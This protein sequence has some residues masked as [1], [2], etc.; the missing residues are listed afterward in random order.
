MRERKNVVTLRKRVMG[1]R[2]PLVLLC[3][4]T[5]AWP[6]VNQAQLD[7]SSHALGVYYAPNYNYVP[8]RVSQ[9]NPVTGTATIKFFSGSVTLAD[10][11]II[12]PFS[13]GTP[14]LVGTGSDQE[15]VTPTAVAG[16][17]LGAP[18]GVC[19][20]TANFTKLHAGGTL[21]SS[22]TFG[23]QE[24]INDATSD[25]GGK[26]VVD[27]SWLG[28][29]SQITS[30]L[31]NAGVSVDD[32]RTG[33]Q[34]YTWNGSSYA[35]QAGSMV[36]PSAGVANSTGSA[37]GAS[38]SVGTAA[39]NLVKLDAS[40]KLPAVDGSQ[41]TNLPSS[42]SGIE[43]GTC[44]AAD[45]ATV[46]MTTSQQNIFT[47]SIPANFFGATGV[48]LR[49][50]ATFHVSSAA[51]AS[52]FQWI[53]G[54]STVAYSSVSTPNVT[55]IRTVLTACE[56]GTNAQY[57]GVEPIVN[58]TSINAGPAPSTSAQST[59]SAITLSVQGA[60]GSACSEVI[61]P[62]FFVVEAVHQ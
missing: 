33:E 61:Q 6:G 62:D 4:L 56:T 59:G 29:T 47:C 19:A 9:G 23:L 17:G 31:G 40:A 3:L 12:T 2:L 42:G 36:Y 26:V 10:G 35:V 49:A 57:L 27:S 46:S 1:V 28:Q 5:F 20:I 16:C 30:A 58:G 43:V 51:A 60:C 32:T 48:C 50:M 45:P 24:A 22:A 8:A 41:L 21:V 52:T 54:S 53:F 44:N 39:N 18:P 13:T 14:L 7:P 55:L 11:R 25:G 15:T 34:L 38:Y 37:W